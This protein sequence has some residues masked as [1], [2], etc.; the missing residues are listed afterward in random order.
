MYLVT[1]SELMKVPVGTIFQRYVPHYLEDLNVFAGTCGSDFLQ[2]Q[3]TPSA[4]IPANG[5]RI[6]RVHGLCGREGYFDDNF[7]YL[8][9]EPADQHRLASWLLNPEEV[10]AASDEETL[11]TDIVT[12]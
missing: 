4:C 3:L 10:L 5:R 9:W 12:E 6:I 7:Q 8:I 11:R 1:R 2:I